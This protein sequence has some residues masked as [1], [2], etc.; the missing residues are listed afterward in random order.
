[1]GPPVPGGWSWEL[2]ARDMN[3][4]FPQGDGN[5]NA[6]AGTKALPGGEGQASCATTGGAASQPAGSVMAS[7]PVPRARMR[8]RPCAGMCPRASP[9]SSWPAVETRLPGSTRTKSVMA[10]T[11][12]GTAQMN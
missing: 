12:A 6:A 4:I 9:A 3:K 7:A 2:E 1:M 8:T 5:G 11:T 10:L